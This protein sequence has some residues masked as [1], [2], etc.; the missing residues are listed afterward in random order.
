[1]LTLPQSPRTG[2]APEQ[3]MPVSC[4]ALEQL[5]RSRTKVTSP[6]CL[7]TLPD[8]VPGVLIVITD[9]LRNAEA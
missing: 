8:N 9:S 5:R 2:V 7:P 1:M 3:A 6:T 4:R